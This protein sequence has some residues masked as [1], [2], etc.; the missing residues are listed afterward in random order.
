MDKM[1]AKNATFK[2][3]VFTLRYLVA[4]LLA[5]ILG[6]LLGF[7]IFKLLECLL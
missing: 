4:L 2:E 6:N 7:A 5:A 1:P 3:P